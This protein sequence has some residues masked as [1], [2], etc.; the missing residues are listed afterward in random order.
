MQVKA[1]R[2]GFANIDGSLKARVGLLSALYA[3]ALQAAIGSGRHVENTLERL[4]ET[5]LFLV[6]TFQGD[7]FD[8]VVGFLQSTSGLLHT[9]LNDIRM[10]GGLQ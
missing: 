1:D 2:R 9:L 6:S 3:L 10:Y 8:R 7:G 4:V 5:A